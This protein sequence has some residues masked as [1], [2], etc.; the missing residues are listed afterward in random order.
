MRTFG[1]SDALCRSRR[2]W[3]HRAGSSLP[4]FGFDP[5]CAAHAL[6]SC[7]SASPF[8]SP[9]GTYTCRGLVVFPVNISAGADGGPYNRTVES[10]VLRTVYCFIPPEYYQHIW[11]SLRRVLIAFVL[12]TA[13]GVPLGLFLGWSQ[14]FKEYIFPVFQLLRPV[15]SLA[16]VPLAII[17]FEG[18]WR[19]I[20]S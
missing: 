18:S 11:V 6:I 4:L 7:C 16:W 3:I 13:A 19:P 1:L 9:F 17:M 8:S 15:L 5:A 2:Q 20:T 14:T 12:A 10:A